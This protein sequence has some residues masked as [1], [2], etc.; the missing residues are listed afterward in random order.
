M[1]RLYLIT[2]IAALTFFAYAQHQGM[3]LTGSR[4]AQQASGKTSSF[5]SGGGRSSTLSHK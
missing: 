2:S 3:T 1:N 5:T 4:G